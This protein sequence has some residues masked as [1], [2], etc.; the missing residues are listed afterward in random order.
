[1]GHDPI[2]A[3]RC[4]RTHFPRY[5]ETPGIK[6]IYIYIDVSL[7]IAPRV[8]P[9]ENLPP[10]PRGGFSRGPV[11]PMGWTKRAPLLPGLD[12]GVFMRPFQVTPTPSMRT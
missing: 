11:W 5:F 6:Y 12:G 10:L 8:I 9:R 2:K 1:M 3:G 7:R 4:K